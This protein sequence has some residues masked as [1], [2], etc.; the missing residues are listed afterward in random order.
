MLASVDLARLATSVYLVRDLYG[1]VRVVAAEQEVDDTT[2][3]VLDSMAVRLSQVLGAHA[4]PSSA[5]VLML[6]TEV[7]KVLG[8]STQK[9]SDRVFWIDRLVTNAGW[10]TIEASEL[11]PRRCTLFSVKGGVGRST[12]AVIAAWHLARRGE[13]VLVVDLDMESPGLSSAALEPQLQPEF[14][15]V[16]WF[17]EDLV[18]QDHHVVE[19]MMAS[20]GWAQD[21]EGSVA[22]VPAHG[23]EPGEYLA[24]LGRVYVGKK[25]SWTN[26]LVSMVSELEGAWRPTTVLIESRSG[27]H[28]IAAATVTD[29]GASVLL[30]ATDSISNWTDY[31]ILFRHWKDHGLAEQMRGRLS[32]VSALTPELGTEEYLAK[33]KEHS[34]DL[35]CDHLYD[36]VDP[37]SEGDEFSFDLHDKSAPHRPV[38]IH[39]NRGFAAGT[40]LHRIEESR[41][42]QAYLKFL[43]FLDALLVPMGER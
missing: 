7:F 43:E 31:R 12:T 9:L 21:L 16:D 40:S 3:D 38:P 5:N 39:W 13:R 28:D 8:P 27:L 25:A 14:G 19:R 34:W 6:D 22:I 37:L 10:W 24:K 23:M 30:F 4:H 2:R 42:A 11:Q 29:L 33:F 36:S 1:R 15:V 35:F 32:I 26:R 20:P 17:V 18:G 41:V